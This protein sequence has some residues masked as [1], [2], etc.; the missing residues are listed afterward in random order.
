MSVYAA[1]GAIVFAI[2]LY[3]RVASPLG[4]AEDYLTTT[5][6]EPAAS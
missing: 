6:A 1:I 3:F 4:H 2:A 5:H